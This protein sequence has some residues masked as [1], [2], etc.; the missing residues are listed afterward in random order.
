MIA[1][2]SSIAIAGDLYQKL[3]QRACGRPDFAS[4]T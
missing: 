4:W 2:T 3:I 1:N